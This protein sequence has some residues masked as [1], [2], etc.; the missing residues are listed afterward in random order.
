M[1]QRRAEANWVHGGPEQIYLEAWRTGLH[2]FK[3][4]KHQE[5][6]VWTPEVDQALSQLK[7]FLSK[8]QSSRLLAKVSSYCSTSL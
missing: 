2:F 7:D 1:H 3:L 6:F 5:K 8:P 4:L